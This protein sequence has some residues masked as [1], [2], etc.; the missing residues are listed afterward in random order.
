MTS[1]LGRDHTLAKAFVVESGKPHLVESSVPT[2]PIAG[3]PPIA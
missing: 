1:P 2:K 3:R